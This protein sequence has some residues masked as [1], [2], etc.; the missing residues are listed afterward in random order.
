MHLNL[1]PNASLASVLHAR[2]VTATTRRLV[3]DV[4]VGCVVTVGALL[5]QPP[6]TMLFAA[7]GACSAAYGAWAFAERTLEDEQ[8]DMPRTSE[9][10]LSVARGAAAIVGI[11]A[12]LVL[13]LALI[14]GTP[15]TWIS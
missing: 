3:L 9:I 8:A 12:A 4:I 5:L 11:G 6:G 7:A 13:L 1:P 10:A 14:S 15:G 2:A